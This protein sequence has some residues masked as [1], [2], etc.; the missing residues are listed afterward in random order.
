MWLLFMWASHLFFHVRH[1]YGIFIELWASNWIII[2]DGD[3]SISAII[4]DCF[5]LI[6]WFDQNTVCTYSLALCRILWLC[7]C[8]RIPSTNWKQP[9]FFWAYCTYQRRLMLIGYL[10]QTPTALLGTGLI[11]GIDFPSW[12]IWVDY[13][14]GWRDSWFSCCLNMFEPGA[15]GYPHVPKCPK[16]SVAALLIWT[17]MDPMSLRTLSKSLATKHR[18]CWAIW[19]PWH[20]HGWMLNMW[21]GDHAEIAQIMSFTVVTLN[22]GGV[23]FRSTCM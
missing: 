22:F 21:S 4:T 18:D 10:P 17:Q 11:C 8:I 16:W 12:I 7:L 20:D 13:H 15:V 19:A 9:H 5:P 1:I 2:D 14:T 3:T 6:C 23:P